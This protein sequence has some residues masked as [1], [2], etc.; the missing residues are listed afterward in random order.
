M[1]RVQHHQNRIV[2]QE[3]YSLEEAAFIAAQKELERNSDGKVKPPQYEIIL[4]EQIN[5]LID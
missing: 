5:K 4:P 2:K 3:E 1:Y